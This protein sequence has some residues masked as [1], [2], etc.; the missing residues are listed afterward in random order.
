MTNHSPFPGQ[1]SLL[2]YGASVLTLG[3]RGFLSHETFSV[4]TRKVL[5]KPGQTGHRSWRNLNQR[6]RSTILFS[7]FILQSFTG[8]F[9]WF[10]LFNVH[11]ISQ[12]AKLK[13]LAM[14]FTGLLVFYTMHNKPGFIPRLLNC[15]LPSQETSGDVQGNI[16]P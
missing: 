2:I 4:K 16:E 14:S 1:T 6:I 15:I 7:F 3:P 12:T 11:L 5:D 13:F 8:T 10:N 9:Q